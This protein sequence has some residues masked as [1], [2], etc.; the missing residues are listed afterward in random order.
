MF[1]V[2]SSRCRGTQSTISI[3]PEDTY[4]TPI[5]QS[6]H[7]KGAPSESTGAGL[8]A[9]TVGS[10]VNGLFLEGA[11]RAA[12]YALCQFAGIV[13]KKSRGHSPTSSPRDRCSVKLDQR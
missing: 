1:C 2:L 5:V 10:S 13:R 4:N 9:L 11:V 3:P 6:S 7:G 8:G 12:T